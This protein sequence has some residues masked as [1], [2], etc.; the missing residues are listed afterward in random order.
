MDKALIAKTVADKLFATEDAVDAA[1]IEASKLL[2]GLIESRQQMNVSTV[3]GNEVVAKVSVALGAL[4][5]ARTAMVDVHNE[6]AEVKLRLGIRAKLIG[7]VDPTK[8]Y[9]ADGAHDGLREV[10]R[11]AS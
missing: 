1:I 9:A 5:E 11:H 8:G 10:R 4:S 7:V 2:A 3:L 6:L